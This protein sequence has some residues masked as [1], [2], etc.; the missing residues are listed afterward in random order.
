MFSLVSFLMIYETL[1]IRA[2]AGEKM[3]CALAD[4]ELNDEMA[5]GQSNLA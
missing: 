1:H 2:F 4:V 5:V 3:D